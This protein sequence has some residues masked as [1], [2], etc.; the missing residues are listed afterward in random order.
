MQL[1][2]HKVS[3][4]KITA[5]QEE[6]DVVESKPPDC[7]LATTTAVHTEIKDSSGDAMSPSVSGPSNIAVMDCQ[8][9]PANA[10]RPELREFNRALS[11]LEMILCCV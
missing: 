2:Q 5:V 11:F 8:M 7:H 9:S 10:S 3:D 1:L 6:T 4:C